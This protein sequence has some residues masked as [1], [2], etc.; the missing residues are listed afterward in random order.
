[1]VAQQKIHNRRGRKKLGAGCVVHYYE[2]VETVRVIQVVVD[3]MMAKLWEMF[4]AS[5]GLSD[6]GDGGGSN[7][8]IIRMSGWTP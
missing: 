4:H 5:G 7:K 6:A 3:P 2:T 8:K 1:M